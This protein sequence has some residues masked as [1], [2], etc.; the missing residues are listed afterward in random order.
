MSEQ[1]PAGAIVVALAVHGVV[2]VAAGTE[3]DD[4]PP[5]PDELDRDGDRR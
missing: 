1:E 3:P 4:G 2:L 5:G